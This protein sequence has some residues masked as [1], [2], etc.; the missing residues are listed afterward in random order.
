MRLIVHV[1]QVISNSASSEADST[2][3]PFAYDNEDLSDHSHLPLSK[4]LDGDVQ[5][6]SWLNLDSLIADQDPDNACPSPTTPVVA[7]RD[8]DLEGENSLCDNL[9]VSTGSVEQGYQFNYPNPGDRAQ[10]FDSSISSGA[11]T[12]A[13]STANS[14]TCPVMV[15]FFFMLHLLEYLPL[16]HLFIA[17]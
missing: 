2:I 4:S 15:C 7:N 13:R 14:M 11:V 9:Y 12:P 6:E 5:W 8:R 16:S 3:Q 17:D 10:S 1:G